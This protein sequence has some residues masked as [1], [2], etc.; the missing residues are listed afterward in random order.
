MRVS[1][2][3]GSLF[4]GLSVIGGGAAALFPEAKLVGAMLIVVGVLAL[5]FD[6]KIDRGHF[7]LGAQPSL[8]ARLRIVAPKLLGL[9][10]ILVL[11]VSFLWYHQNSP[12][13]RPQAREQATSTLSQEPPKKAY[14]LT[15]ARRK[16]FLELLKTTQSEPR[17]TLR[18]GCVTWSEAA[19]LS[20]GKFLI[21]F[22]EAGWEI[23]SDR[24]HKMEPDIPVDGMTIATRKVD[25]DNLER[26]PP[27]LGRWARI[28]Q[29]HATILMAFTNMDI[30]VRFANDPSLPLKTLGIYFGPE[31]VLTSM[32]T[33]AQKDIR[34]SLMN[35]LSKA[36]KVEQACSQGLNEQCKN[37]QT[38]WEAEVLKYLRSH[39]FDSTLTSKWENLSRNTKDSPIESIGKQ[40]NLLITIFFGLR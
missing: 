14:D 6:V 15:E 31:P 38:P 3:S 39:G 12:V 18:I 11:V 33:P 25:I 34:K 8:S 30:P 13:E 1:L 23:D 22:S 35:F 28:D 37:S 4:Q 24:V 17:D 29:S 10:L 27:H 26:L 20:A 7:Q 32:S 19:C 36:T 40:K 9:V 2:T 5:V 21:L 16:D